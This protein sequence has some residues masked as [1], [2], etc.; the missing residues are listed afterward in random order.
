MTRGVPCHRRLDENFADGAGGAGDSV[1]E[2]DGLPCSSDGDAEEGWLRT[3]ASAEDQGPTA[4]VSDVRTLDGSGNVGEK[5]DVEEEEIPDMDD[6]EDDN[7]AIIRDPHSDG[8]KSYAI[9]YRD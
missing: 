1:V 3:G 4:T 5:E 9:M 7:E 6:E 8:S 2:K